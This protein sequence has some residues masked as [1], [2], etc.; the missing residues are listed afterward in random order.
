MTTCVS[1]AQA[2]PEGARFC[3]HCG[4]EQTAP[5]CSSCGATLVAGA[6]FCME[7]GTPT[8]APA[9]T[10]EAHGPVASRRLTSILFGDLVGFTTLSEARDTEDVR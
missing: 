8:A 2:L 10:A 9:A 4:Q 5:T 7:C 1:C 3:L 6:R